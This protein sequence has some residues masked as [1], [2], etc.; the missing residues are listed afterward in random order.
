MVPARIR[1]KD[2]E[3]WTLSNPETRLPDFLQAHYRSLVKEAPGSDTWNDWLRHGRVVLLLDGVDEIEDE[4]WFRNMLEDLLDYRDTM[5]VLTIRT[6]AFR[7]HKPQFETISVYWL[8]PLQKTQRDAYIQ[9]YP[10]RHEFDR[11]RLIEHLDSNPALQSFGENPLLLSMICF[12]MDDPAQPELPQTRAALYDRF[13]DHLLTR[14]ERVRIDYPGEPPSARQKKRA[15]AHVAL[16]LLGQQRFSFTSDDLIHALGSAL[17]EMGYGSAPAPWANALGK[18]L[19]ANS[20]LL[21][22]YRNSTNTRDHMQF[23]LHAMIHE[24]LSACALA[25][26]LTTGDCDSKIDVA[27]KSCSIRALVSEIAWTDSNWAEVV[28]L[29][30]ELLDSDNIHLIN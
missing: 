6:V 18:D 11:I 10:A 26:L 19:V 27:G 20:A 8:G 2:W 16:H 21:R 14:P 13:V 9:T 29:L 22:G 3:R 15:L 1:I 30:G 4:A 17:E 28:E 5:L 25:L 24:Y 12:A 23:F 7:L